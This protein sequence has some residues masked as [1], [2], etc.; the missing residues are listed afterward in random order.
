MTEVGMEGYEVVTHDDQRYGRV[1][2]VLG[3]TIVVER[4]TIFKHKTA[5]P[6][7]MTQ[8]D[9]DA[10]VVRTTLSKELLDDA[11]TVEGESVDQQAVATYYGLAGGV[12][13]PDTEG[14][15]ELR[16]GDPATTAE[17]DAHR[18][19]VGTAEEE[20]LRVRKGEGAHDRG[21]SPGLAGGDRFRDAG[22]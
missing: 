5:L 16:P 18:F 11:P 15:G 2:R 12:E 6:R 22:S 4:G 14:Y 8:V 1:A 7:E 3:E 20:R 19:G 10:K 13:A 21:T 9:E 17:Q